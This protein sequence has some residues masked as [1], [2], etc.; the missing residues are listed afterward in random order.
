[1]NLKIVL[2]EAYKQALMIED[3]NFDISSLL[4]S[5]GEIE[6]DSLGSFEFAEVVFEKIGTRIEDNEM[7]LIKYPAKIFELC[8][9]K[10]NKL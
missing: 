2:N 4:L 3:D 10:R 1:M 7:H 6:I 8:S 9:D 5:E